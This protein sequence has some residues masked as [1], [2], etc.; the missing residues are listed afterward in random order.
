MTQADKKRTRAS[1]GA[2][3]T[4]QGMPKVVSQQEWD[5]AR[6]VFLE[7]EKAATRARDE[8]NAERRRLPMVR[9]EKDYVFEGPDGAASLPDLFEGRRQLI[10]YHFM[11]HADND[12]FCPGCSMFADQISHLSHLHARNTSFALISR[13]PLGSIARHK[14]RMGW[15]APWYSSL[16]SDFNTDFGLT[17]DDGEMFGLSVFF[18]DDEGNVYRTYFTDRR[19]VETLGSVWTFL[20]LTPWGRQETWE[21]SPEG[22][23]QTPPY[24]WWRLH[25]EYPK[26]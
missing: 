12:S 10:V 18:R 14:A 22:W 9:I 25:D 16:K 26:R 6:K 24:E 8:L 4:L 23:P 3:E 19:G 15:T 5:A 21:N 1:P 17:T 20:D 11:Y 7:K 2:A 13:A